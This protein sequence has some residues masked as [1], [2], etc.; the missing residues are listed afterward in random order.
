MV[1]LLM[2]SPCSADF[3]HVGVSQNRGNPKSSTLVGFSLINHPFWV[4]PHGEPPMWPSDVRLRFQWRRKP[5]RTPRARPR[6]RRLRRNR[7][8]KRCLVG[9]FQVQP[10][11]QYLLRIFP[12]PVLF[13]MLWC[14][15]DILFSLFLSLLYGDRM[16]TFKNWGW[17]ASVFSFFLWDFHDDESPRNLRFDMLFRGKMMG[18]S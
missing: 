16:R 11:W 3:H 7:R 9:R 4:Y 13:S 2:S 1:K 10:R 12:D 5:W 18:S 8:P 14:I 6:A 15:Y 17:F